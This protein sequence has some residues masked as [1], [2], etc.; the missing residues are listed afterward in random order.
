MVKKNVFRIRKG[1]ERKEVEK[2]RFSQEKGISVL[3]KYSWYLTN[4]HFIYRNQIDK[5]SL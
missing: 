1:K 2:G 4:W 3:L 5:L